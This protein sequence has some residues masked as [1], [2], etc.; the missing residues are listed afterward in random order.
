MLRFFYYKNYSFFGILSLGVFGSFTSACSSGSGFNFGVPRLS[1]FILIGLGAPEPCF[2][3]LFADK[4][5]K[6]N[7]FGVG[8]DF[9]DD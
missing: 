5:C 1:Y 8:D 9:S 2:L 4:G 3:P 6:S 7:N